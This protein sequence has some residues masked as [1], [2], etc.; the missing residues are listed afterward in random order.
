MPTT[1]DGLFFLCL[2]LSL[3]GSYLLGSINFAIIV[4]RLFSGK[5]I[6]E[7]GSGNAGMTNVLRTAGKVPALLTLL[8]DVSKGLLAVL[9]TRWLFGFLSPQPDFF[10]GDY[11]SV[12]AALLGHCFPIFY[13]FKG[14]KG[15]LVS[16]GALLVLSPMG[17]AVSLVAF[18]IGVGVTKTVSVGS[19]AAA[20]VFP[21]ATLFIQWR[22]ESTGGFLHVALSALIAG[23]IIFMH[24]ANLR[25]LASGTEP[26]TF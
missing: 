7:S 9:L 10:L 12:C 5:D 14:G 24:R 4:T 22:G 26:K 15:V 6:R 23:I 16:A 2:M 20:A 8:G 13:G 19:I 11:L 21:L 1:M 3:V 18:V 25:R 17:F